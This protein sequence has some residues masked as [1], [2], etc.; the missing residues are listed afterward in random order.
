MH[1]QYMKLAIKEAK[2]AAIKDEV[3]IGCVIVDPIGT[4]ISKAYNWREHN[5][6]STAH[7]E[8]RAI[9]RA[10]KKLGSW[11]LEDCTLY[12]TVEPCP[13]CAG[14]I[15]QARIKHVVYGA[16]DPKGGC[17][18]SCMKMFETPGF[19]HYPTW[20]GGVLEQECATLMKDFFRVKR[21]QK[22]K[23]IVS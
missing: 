17:V 9:E 18:D 16:Y 1:E 8:V 5:Q 6:L 2:K 19:N 4:V 21:L 15:V 3:P 20:Q 10:C 13:M 23:T 22:A 11:R 7:A 12:V 14:A